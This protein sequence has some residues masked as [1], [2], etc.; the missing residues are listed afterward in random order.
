VGAFPG[1]R[2][3]CP[4]RPRSRVS[5][6]PETRLL[7]RCQA[8]SR[9]QHTFQP[10]S[11]K[12]LS[13]MHMM[14]ATTCCSTAGA[15][16]PA[17]PARVSLCACA[18]KEPPLPAPSRLDEARGRRGSGG[19]CVAGIQQLRILLADQRAE[20]GQG[21]ETQQR[22]GWALAPPSAEW[23]CDAARS[24]VAARAYL[25]LVEEDLQKELRPLW[26]SR[27]HVPVLAAA[28]GEEKQVLQGGGREGL[29]ALAAGHET[30]GPRGKWR[31]V[32]GPSGAKR[33]PVTL[34]IL[35]HTLCCN[36]VGLVPQLLGLT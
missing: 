12:T 3:E 29:G 4:G 2:Q 9:W 17:L 19:V 21:E 27:E 8:S 20:D 36:S 26:T 14:A 35:E 7:G 18:S 30:P 34:L 32:Q 31:G 11:S 28:P 5:G 33:M 24:R 23:P 6:A 1:R 16:R 10:P 15:A 25:Q 13:R 22:P